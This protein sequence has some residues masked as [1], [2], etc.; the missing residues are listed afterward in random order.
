MSRQPRFA[1]L[2]R[3]NPG[4]VV[5]TLRLTSRPGARGKPELTGQLDGGGSQGVVVGI[6]TAVLEAALERLPLWGTTR[7]WLER[8]VLPL[9]EPPDGCPRFDFRKP[10]GDPGIF[11][12]EAVVCRVNS[13]P[14]SLFTGGV[15]AVLFELAEPRVRSGVWDHTDFR[16]DPIGRL[17]R[18]GVAAMVTT[19][20]F[21]GRPRDG[22]EARPQD[23]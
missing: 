19:Y 12:P 17:R 23:A 6:D 2:P 20:G 11:G 9:N 15:A 22:D 8:M 16:T 18:T 21:Q 3:W 5:S 4:L 14:V 13:N 7:T 10:A 1:A